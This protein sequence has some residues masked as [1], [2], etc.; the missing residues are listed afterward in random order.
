MEESRVKTAKEIV[1]R[2]GLT[3]GLY[4][5]LGDSYGTDHENSYT[6]A[7]ECCEQYAEQFKSH[8]INLEA[9]NKE[10]EEALQNVV[11]SPYQSPYDIRNI[12]EQ[13]LNKK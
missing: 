10:L 12:A 13:A 5:I 1:E 2:S 8:I 3:D 9:R 7:I 11:N 4:D 6:V